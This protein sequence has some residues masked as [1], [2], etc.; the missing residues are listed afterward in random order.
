MNGYT[1]AFD[2]TKTT[3]QLSDF[4][5]NIIPT[6]PQFHKMEYYGSMI[7]KVTEAYPVDYYE[8]LLSGK[9]WIDTK[10]SEL[11]TFNKFRN[12]IFDKKDLSVINKETERITY[13]GNNKFKLQKNINRTPFIGIHDKLHSEH[14]QFGR[15]FERRDGIQGIVKDGSKITEL[16]V[17]MDD[18]HYKMI[19]L[20]DTYNFRSIVK[21]N[22]PYGDSFY[23]IV[24]SANVI[25]DSASFDLVNVSELYKYNFNK[26]NVDGVEV[27]GGYVVPRKYNKTIIESTEFDAVD[28]NIADVMWINAFKGTHTLT[29]VPN[30]PLWTFEDLDDDKNILNI[31]FNG[32]TL[33]IKVTS[34][35]DGSITKQQ[36]Q[37]KINEPIIFNPTTCHTHVYTSNLIDLSKYTD[38]EDASGATYEITID[39]TVTTEAFP[40]YK[41]LIE[42]NDT[43]ILKIQV[44]ERTSLDISREFMVV[45]NP[46]CFINKLVKLEFVDFEGNPVKI[47]NNRHMDLVVPTNM[48]TTL[49]IN[50]INHNVFFVKD[51]DDNEDHHY[52]RVL[53]NAI[54]V[55][56]AARIADSQYLS[57]A[58]D[59]STL[60]LQN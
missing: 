3:G 10:D 18:P 6:L 14:T 48:W 51:F 13:L 50:E 17:Y 27:V 9:I 55:E 45:I 47:V 4:S 29:K 49:Q 22:I 38:I 36:Y 1:I 19:R 25:N 15:I 7:G 59:L 34:G 20:Y 52:V 44:P 11:E 8:D 23:D 35:N 57:N 30:E 56:S 33:Y 43:D 42:E 39:P 28:V 40:K 41:L 21:E 37:V 54:D 5:F 2:D 60:E 31:M 12:V 16:N 32:T 46:D 26:I 53:S 24:L 58:I